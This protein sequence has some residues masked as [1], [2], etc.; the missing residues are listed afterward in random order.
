MGRSRKCHSCQMNLSRNEAHMKLWRLSI[1]SRLTAILAVSFLGFACGSESG[2]ES[3]D[4]NGTERSAT[5][6]SELIT[7]GEQLLSRLAQP[8]TE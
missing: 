6:D 2:S 8:A 5:Q 7:E 3:G 1:T 4:A